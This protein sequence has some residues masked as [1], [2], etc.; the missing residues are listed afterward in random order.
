[1]RHACPALPCHPVQQ[2]QQ[3]RCA[4][5]AA[6]RSIWAAALLL[7][8]H[9]LPLACQPP[10]RA[11]PV[12]VSR[13]A[14]P[15]PRLCHLSGKAQGALD[16][17]PAAGWAW[18]NCNTTLWQAL[19]RC[20][21]HFPARPTLGPPVTSMLGNASCRPSKQSYTS[22]PADECASSRQL[23]GSSASSSSSAAS[24]AG[25]PSQ[26]RHEASLLHSWGQLAAAKARVVYPGSR[27]SSTASRVWRAQVVCW[28]G[29]QG[30][31]S[32]GSKPEEEHEHHAP[33]GCTYPA[34]PTYPWRHAV[35]VG[36]AVVGGPAQPDVRPA[37]QT[38]RALCN[39]PPRHLR[40]IREGGEACTNTQADA[41]L[42]KLFSR[43]LR[44]LEK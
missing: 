1:M 14:H 33:Q 29:G 39:Q 15:R 11:A 38:A 25:R 2:R 17:K 12:A 28:L 18:N 4:G 40:Q 3:R 43:L 31:S 23:R 5:T 22:P 21:R 20:W 19:P 26:A 24:R 27:P 16:C 34:T 9:W 35:L 37:R 32:T 41:Q 30:P 8:F 44:R 7:A 42:L 13:R 10:P 36:P 6:G